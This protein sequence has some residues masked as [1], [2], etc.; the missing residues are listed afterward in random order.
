LILGENNEKMSKSRGNVVNPDEMVE[1]YGA[2]ALRLYE[3]FMG[4]FDQPIPW[5][6][7]GL[8]GM[9]RFLFR[10]WELHGRVKP[11]ALEDSVI[12]RMIHQSIRKVSEDIET[13]KFNTALAQLMT[14][15]NTLSRSEAIRRQ[16]FEIL[17]LLL[18]PFAP[19]IAEELWSALG[20]STLTALEPW[21][22]FD[23][24]MLAAD[25]VTVVV[26]VNGKLRAEFQASPDA[27]K[28]DLE[29]AARSLEKVM[30]HLAG[31]NVRKVIVVPGK[32]VNIVAN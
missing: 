8:N 27:S 15:S 28:D 3:M 18:A 20:H 32:L 10:V 25:K 31:K 6:T 5:S 4:A 19:H 16:D 29:A 23:E 22:R 1:K 21:P 13:T 12:T 26:Q 9:Q 30:V 17:V 7:A 24:A 11:D 2:D 14:L